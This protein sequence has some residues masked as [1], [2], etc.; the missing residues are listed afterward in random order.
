[1]LHYRP[2]GSVARDFMKDQSFFTG[3]Q[4]PVGSG[5]SSSCCMKIMK[6][7]MEMPR[8][9]SGKRRSKW[10]VIRNTYPELK[11]TTI[12]TWLE[13][14]PEDKFGRFIWT[15]PYTHLLK[16]ADVELEVL[17]MALDTEAD[18]GKLLSLDLTGIWINEAREIPKPI[19]DAATLR[20]GRFPPRRDVNEFWSG[21]IVDTNAPPDDHWFAIMSGQA[22]VPE[23]FSD[24]DR[25][26]L[27][28]PEDWTF[29]IQPGAALEQKDSAGRTTG[30]ELNPNAENLEALPA[31]YYK[32]GMT[33]KTNDY[34]RVFIGNKIGSARSGR[35]VYGN[36]SSQLHVGSDTHMPDPR[37]PMLLGI[38]FGLTPAVI[39]AQRYAD[40]SWFVFD[41]L[42]CRDMGFKR[43][44]DHIKERLQSWEY[45][46]QADLEYRAWGDP[47]G[48]ARSPYDE[49]ERTA[50]QLLEGYG[51]KARAAPSN[52]PV[53][54]IES[55]DSLL[56]GLIDG[57]PMM[58]VAPRCK[59]LIRGF[60]EGYQYPKKKLLGQMSGDERP[61]KNQYSHPH[62]GWQYI[63]L[64]EG[65]GKELKRRPGKSQA[66]PRVA[67][68]PWNP[69]DRQ[70]A[71]HNRT[72]RLR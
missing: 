14:F 21:M 1:M 66:K 71:L 51:V 28:T 62:D 37:L 67:R 13:W 65:V 57:H 70:S 68:S 6:Q 56:T 64:G 42:V 45:R 38:D 63:V 26:S 23:H 29:Y 72:P 58:Q 41:E 10:A 4:G 46:I 12:E 35:P 69:Y 47:A 2:P 40:L 16:F 17:F 30:W 18:V 5:K 32:N 44:A 11:T 60:E 54:R 22:P 15:P 61:E 24:E 59:V 43:L 52:D 39:F 50:F 55:V 36:W 19:I 48:D 33:G 34:I 49:R 8:D 20:L 7:A 25:L 3:I 53:L 9:K 27:V 31:H